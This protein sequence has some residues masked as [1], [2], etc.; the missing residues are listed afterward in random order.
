MKKTLLVTAISLALL[1]CN[2][3]KTVETE[4]AATVEAEKVVLESGILVEGMDTSVK[5][6]DDFNQY[7]N[8]NWLK[9]TK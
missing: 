1:G 4:S 7:V 6:G 8:G 2:E 5:P 9:K 3:S